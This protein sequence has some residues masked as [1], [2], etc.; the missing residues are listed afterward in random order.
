[1]AKAE[2][3]AGICG[4][5]TTVEVKVNGSCDISIDSECQSIQKL[6]A[7]LKHVNP[8]EE[9]SFRGEGPATL[10]M[11][12]KHCAHAACPV[13]AGIIKAVEIA[14]GLALPADATIKLSK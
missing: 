5:N 7:S 11:A 8:F 6:G 14:A 3:F 13:P 2:I 9:I 10:R 4:F 1:M 12:T